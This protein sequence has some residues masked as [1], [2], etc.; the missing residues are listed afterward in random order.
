MLHLLAGDVLGG[1]VAGHALGVEG[2]CPDGLFVFSGNKQ[3]Q[4]GVL[5]PDGDAFVACDGGGL[6]DDGAVLERLGI[7]SGVG[8]G[9]YGKAVEG[10]IGWDGG[11]ERLVEGLRVRYKNPCPVPTPFLRGGNFCSNSSSTGMCQVLVSVRCRRDG[12]K[13]QVE[14]LLPT[15]VTGTLVSGEYHQPIPDGYSRI[16]IPSR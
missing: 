15:G 11:L 7:G 3:A 9:V 4:Q 13:M 10:L 14:V 16:E 8:C 12:E 2:Q 1:V 5:V 6:V